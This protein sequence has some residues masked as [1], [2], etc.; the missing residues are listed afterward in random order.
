LHERLLDYDA[1]SHQVRLLREARA[2]RLGEFREMQQ[3]ADDSIWISGTFGVA[4]LQGPAR[5]ITPQTVWG[6]FLLPKTNLVNTLQRPSEYPPGTVTLSANPPATTGGRFVVQWHDDRWSIIPIETEKI[7]QAWGGWDNSIWGYSANTLLRIEPAPAPS[8]RKELVAGTQYDVA[9]ETNGVFWIAS[10]EG[11][12]RHAPFL[13]RPRPDLEDL[14]SAVH[15]I[16]FD[17][18]NA[19]LATS[20]GLLLT[21]GRPHQL[22]PWPEEIEGQVPPRESLFRLNDGRL[23]ISA[24][25]NPVL[26]DPKAEP[27]KKRFSSLR[28]PPALHA[29]LLGQLLD[30]SVCVWLEHNR[31]DRGLDLRIFDGERFTPIEIPPLQGAPEGLNRNDLTFV[32]EL[33]KGDLWIGAGGDLIRLR[34]TT[35][36]VEIHSAE[37][38]LGGERI[39]AISAVGEGRIW[40]GAASKVYEYRGRRWE[41][42]LTTTDRITAILPSGGS[43]WVATASGIYRYMQDSWIFHSVNEGLPAGAIYAL[44]TGPNDLLWAGAS[45]G[46]LIFHPDADL[47][48]PHALVPSLQEAQKPS[49][50]VPTVINFHG[51]DKWDYT[52]PSDLL[53][54]YKLDE[55]GW[56]PFSNITSHVFQN[57]SSG[58][59]LL[60]VFAM[61]K[62]GNKSPVANH[63]Q[64]S[65]IVPWFRDPRLLIVS[66]LALALILVFGGIAV[67][68]HFELKR[69]YTEVE[70]IVQQRTRQLEEANQELLHGQK[71]RAIGTMAAGIAHDFNNIL[72]IIKGSAQI[73]EDHPDDREKIHT[74]VSRIQM[75]VEQG[76]TIVKALLGLG[77]MSEQDLVTCDI[78]NLL[79]ETRK[80]LGDRF[81]ETL[82]F[83]VDAS[84]DLPKVLC[85]QEVLQQILLNFILNAADAMGNEG[86]LQLSA[87]EAP[88][89]PKDIV[90]AAASAPSYVV[91]TVTDEGG[92]ISPENLPRIF[93]PFFTTK[94]LS[95]RRGTGLG[96]SM[97][98]ELAKGLGYGLAVDTKLGEG[99]SFSIFLPVDSPV[100][101]PEKPRAI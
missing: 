83:H 100:P 72:S 41:R 80:I 3:G 78:G 29:H 63:V 18:T 21:S 65:V 50:L 57:L 51:R 66:V 89:L 94:A 26:F 4:H 98:Y 1:T 34:L 58:K 2:T 82:Q 93:E 13:W 27:E 70:R 38:G 86:L 6:E 25:T 79:H 90:L 16:S 45:R 14:Q 11:L 60:E 56:T 91:V 23:L 81:P 32:K 61:D 73:I 101:L 95:S 15:A 64:F 35:G 97:V 85:S 46:V 54:S 44:R 31:P 5:R 71:M 36:A 24:Q 49:T 48:P 17:G 68:N 43:V 39:L 37:Q 75:V 76:T 59:H 22:F 55:G 33:A 19:I 67:N 99:S 84:A 77:R 87:R 20:E 10:S 12:V 52:L 92:G 69:S 88:A 40:C 42:I 47:D 53:F 62:N 96:L 30:G 74:R 8:F 9:V 28:T 7:R